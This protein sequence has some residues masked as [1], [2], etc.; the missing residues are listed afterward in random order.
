[1][2]CT[3]LLVV[4]GVDAVLFSSTVEQADSDTRAAA[5]RHAI[6]SFFIS[7]ILVY[8]VTLQ[9]EITPSFGHMLWGVTLWCAPLRVTRVICGMERFGLLPKLLENRAGT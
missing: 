2:G 4:L 3:A 7:K 1:M 8:I 9:Y 5:A 6:M